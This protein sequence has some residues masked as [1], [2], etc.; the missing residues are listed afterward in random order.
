MSDYTVH[1]NATKR[2]DAQAQE[3]TDEL[4]LAY[5]KAAIDRHKDNLEATDEMIAKTAETGWLWHCS[6]SPIKGFAWPVPDWVSAFLAE[7]GD[8]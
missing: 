1:P 7:P 6:E 2:Q 3:K 5:W 4:A 8:E